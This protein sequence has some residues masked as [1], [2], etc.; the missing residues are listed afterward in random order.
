MSFELHQ[1]TLLICLFLGN[2]FMVLLILAYRSRF[3]RDRIYMLFVASKCMQ[4]GIL[5]LLLLEARILPPVLPLVA[6]LWLAAGVVETMA[7]LLLVG[8]YS[9]K[10]MEYYRL[11]SAAAL[12]LL[13]A[14]VIWQ[15]RF[16]VASAALSGSLLMTYPAYILLVRIRET[17]LQR[18]MGWLYAVV[19]LALAGRALVGVASGYPAIAALLHLF[20][21]T[22]IFLLMFLG[23][24]GFMLLSREQAY[25]ELTRVATYD[26]LTG[27]LNRRSFVLRARPLIAAAAL[28][29]APYSFLLLDLDHFKSVNDTYGHDTGDKVLRDFAA[30]IGQQLHN[31]ELFGRFGGEEF[32][33][34]LHRADM[35]ASSETAERLRASLSGAVINGAQLP[36]SVSIGVITVASGERMSLNSLYKLSDTALYRAKQQGRN[37]VERSEAGGA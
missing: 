11:L 19:A 14:F 35:Q 22:G 2:F 5:L 20:F 18:A 36:Y 28:Q 24:S 30:R 8:M 32:A 23:T 12:F 21:Y 3:S 34:L 26:E 9:H 29:G 1:P 16:T 7:I 25:A 37:R 15:G 27:I 4:L 33:I 6:L 17:A 13:L 10:M 31:G